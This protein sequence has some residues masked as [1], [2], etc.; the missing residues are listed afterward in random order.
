[1][2]LFG[3]AGVTLGVAAALAA[4]TFTHLLLD[5]MWNTPATLF[6]PFLGFAFPKIDLE[7]WGNNLFHT[8]FHDPAVYVTEIIGLAVC[9]WFAAEIV[10]R[11]K[12]IA[13]IK[14][15]RII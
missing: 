5:G 3:H 11:K 9:L 7:G 4:G 8:L 2:L 10:R 15:G 1:M 12:I 6:G 14:Y 13:F